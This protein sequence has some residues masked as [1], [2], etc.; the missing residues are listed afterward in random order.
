M[1]MGSDDSIK[2][3]YLL[4]EFRN[5]NYLEAILIF[6]FSSARLIR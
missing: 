6:D 3:R 2:I 5:I 4:A 1:V